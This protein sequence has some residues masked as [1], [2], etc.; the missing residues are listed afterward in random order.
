MTERTG[1]FAGDNPFTIA[2]S[3]LAEAQESE[4]N[5]P[6]AIAL[7]TVD[8]DGMPNARMVLLKGVEPDAFVFYT[9]YESAKARELDGAGKAAFVMHWKSLRRQIRVR[10]HVSREDG[11]A[12]D[13]YFASR[14]L[15][16]RLGA[17]ASKQSR[18]LSSRAALMAE[19]AKM[20]ATHGTNPKRPPFWGGFRIT[21]VEI[22]F[23]ADGDF[24][25]HDRF[26][27]R[28]ETPQSEWHVTRLNP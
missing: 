18:P 23:W 6:N 27:W 28:R 22:E 12:A 19:V 16:S 26:V 21:P 20:T 11:D 4:V 1:K 10:G 15:K 3:W 14:S 8:A 25:L 24:R 9:N 2:E 17:W 5:D 13:A 7:S